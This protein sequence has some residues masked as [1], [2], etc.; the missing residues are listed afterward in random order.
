MPTRHFYVPTRFTE[1]VAGY[2]AVTSRQRW[3]V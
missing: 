1:G 2:V 3:G